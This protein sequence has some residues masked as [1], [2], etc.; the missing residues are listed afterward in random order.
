MSTDTTPAER[1]RYQRIDIPEGASEVRPTP[2]SERRLRD[3]FARISAIGFDRIDHCGQLS[4]PDQ[5]IIPVFE[6]NRREP[7]ERDTTS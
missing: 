1:S 3:V 6:K 7:L 5:G 4:S 2:Q